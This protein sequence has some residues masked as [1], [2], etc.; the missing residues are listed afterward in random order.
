MIRYCRF[1]SIMN[2][3]I[4]YGLFIVFSL[5]C[6][7][8]GSLFILKKTNIVFALAWL[9]ALIVANEIVYLKIGV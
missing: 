3:L 8:F 2:S 4:V 7:V 1:L 9:L 5:F 6:A